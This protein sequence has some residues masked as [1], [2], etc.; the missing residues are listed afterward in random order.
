DRPA[1]TGRSTRPSSRAGTLWPRRRGRRRG[2][3]TRSRSPQPRGPAPRA[4]RAAAGASPGS[5]GARPGRGEPTACLVRIGRDLRAQRVD[6]GE[7]P[8]RA[9][10][11][12][13][14]ELDPPLVEVAAPIERLRLR[15]HLLTALEGRPAPRG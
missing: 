6:A 1:P 3:R 4:D 12:R 7:L 14:R 8:L 5:G 13:K 10:P 2:A 11:D 9:Q 15:E